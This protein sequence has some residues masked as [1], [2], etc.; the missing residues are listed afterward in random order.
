MNPTPDTAA[1]QAELLPHGALLR[2]QAHGVMLNLFPGNLMEGGPANLW[3]RL[4]GDASVQAVPLLGPNSPLQPRNS[5]GAVAWAA[6]GVWQGLALQLQLRLAAGAAAWFWHLDVHNT[7]APPKRVDLLTVQDV[8]LAPLGAIRLNEYYV[9]HYLD[10]SPLQHPRHGVLLAARQNQPVAGRSPWL[11]C[12]ALQGAVSYATDALQL[13]GLAQRNGGVAPA[14]QQGLAGA[15]LQQEHALLALQHVARDLVPGESALF[16]SFGLALADHPAATSAADLA[17]ADTAANLPE[18]QPLALGPAAAGCLRARSAASL[19]ASTPMLAVQDLTAGQLKHLFPGP[20]RHVEH[21]DAGTLL[22]FFHDDSA[23]V[24]LRAKEA[25]VIRPHGHLLRSGHHAVPDETALTS[26]V[27]MAGV[28]HSLVTQGH[29]GINQCLS[30]VRGALGQF[31]AHGQ[32]IFMDA[33]HGWQLLG[34]PSAFEL[35]PEACRWLY[36]HADGLLE[37]RSGVLHAPHALTLDLRVLEGGPLKLRISHHVTLGGDDGVTPAAP[38]PLRADGRGVCVGV[39]A[40]STLAKR[41]PQGGFVIAPDEHSAF[42]RWG[43]DE[44]LFAD[45]RPQGQPWLVIDGHASPRFGL[46]LEGRLVERAAPPALPLSAPQWQAPAGSALAGASQRVQDIAPWYLHNALVHYLSPRG[47]EQFS[48]GGWGTRDVCQGPLEML[49]ALDQP[50]PVRDLLQRVFAAQDAG[51]DWPQWF[52]FFE[53]ERGIR[54]SDAH[55]DIVFWPLVG[56][57]RY[58]HATGD[59]ALLD[60]SLPYFNDEPAPLWQHVERA[61]AVI[62]GRRIAGTALAAYGHGDWNDSLQPADPALREHLCSAWTV[63]LHHQML[64]G[65]AT[66]LDSLGQPERAAPLHAEAAAVQADFQRLLMP[67]GVVAGYTLFEPGRPAQPLL[68]PRDERTGVHYSLLPMMHA[69]LENLLT[70]AQ[71]QAQAALIEMHLTG[72]DGARLFDRPLAYRGGPMQFF[73][74]AE[75]SAF[76][77]REIGVMYMHAHLRWAEM[78]AHLGQAERFFH[79]VQLAHPIA[80]RTLVPQATRRQA[81]CYYSSSDAAFPDR[82]SASRDYARVVRGEVALDGGWRVY[83]SGPGIAL[84]LI[85][86][87]FLG[88]RRESSGVVFD[89]VLPPALA[90]L[91]ARLPLLG[92]E[93]ELELQPGPLGHGPMAVLLGGEPLPFTREANAYRMGGARVTHADLRR[94]LAAGARRLV[95]HTG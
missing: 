13:L 31:R 57:A 23:H 33:G 77:G 34:V 82:T 51:G 8:G 41:F 85:V 60:K 54:A 45:G 29:V 83:S 24:V 94:R 42:T 15:R 38:L 92:C 78:L 32:R 9:S 4:H 59:V 40:G 52:M 84:G 37:V 58:L 64:H 26:T 20:P 71:A 66:A 35:R 3:L 67:D 27:W 55:G 16:G 93:I 2:L 49:L 69:V 21:D 63:T 65:L 50:A 14:L 12:G 7:G 44:M 53:R 86:G 72:P 89:P 22:S 74:R 17:W 61:L 5:G 73:Q 39:P 11:L 47:L 76:F 28:F 19:F 95:V 36:R 87:R 25:A 56:L 75:S 46:R 79:A 1:L 88:L 43:G 90:G 48:G 62:H 80:L 10:L 70:P 6:V 18:A 68:H 81:N 91:V 30:T